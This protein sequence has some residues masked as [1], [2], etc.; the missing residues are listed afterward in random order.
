MGVKRVMR[1]CGD[2]L[3]LD[4]QVA[5]VLS[6]HDHQGGYA[7]DAATGT[8]HVTL[9]SPLNRGNDGDCF[10]CVDIVSPASPGGGGGGGGGGDIGG[11]G[12]GGCLVVRGPALAH[13]VS[14]RLH[15][16][17]VGGL[18]RTQPVGEPAGVVQRQR[19]GPVGSQGNSG[20]GGGGGGD[21]ASPEN[22]GLPPCSLHRS[23][24]GDEC[25]MLLL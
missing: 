15:G 25:L 3:S 9:Q 8:H 7:F 14:P 11:I 18:A 10:G 1:L 6:G 5:L 19:E 21:G 20:G 13:L 17:L 16:A 4:Q 12:G 22:G 24:D 23:A 2:S